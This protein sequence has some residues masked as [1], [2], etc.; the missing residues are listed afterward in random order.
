LP[1][2]AFHEY[3]GI[4]AD[5]PAFL[6]FCHLALPVAFRPKSA[7]LP[8]IAF[9]ETSGKIAGNAISHFWPNL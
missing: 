3:P 2:I 4:F 9:R 5:G 7:V 6:P 1:K 8:K